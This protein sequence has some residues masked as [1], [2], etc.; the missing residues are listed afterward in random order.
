MEFYIPRVGKDFYI[1]RIR[2]LRLISKAESGTSINLLDLED[3]SAS[4]HSKGD[5]SGHNDK[6]ASL[7]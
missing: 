4:R 2:K 3:I 1:P 7:G 6:V 5:T